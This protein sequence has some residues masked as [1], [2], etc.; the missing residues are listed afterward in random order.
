MPEDTGAINTSLDL[1][2][3]RQGH[4]IS[5]LTSSNEDGVT[6]NGLSGFNTDVEVNTT[7]VPNYRGIALKGPV[8]VQGWGRD[9]NGDPVPLYVDDEGSPIL[10]IG[11]NKQ[12]S[13][14][15]LYNSKKHKTGPLDIS[16]DESRGV[17]TGG[18]G[19][20]RIRFT[21]LSAAFTVGFGA[22]GCDHVVVQV[23]HISCGGTGVSV[24]DEVNVYDP[25][26]CHFNLPIELLVGLNGT[27]TLM[28]SENYQTDV[29]YVVDCVEELRNGGCMWM[30]DTLCCSEEEI[31]NG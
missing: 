17:W 2:P 25:E 31:I 12:F 11:G 10:D 20:P 30:I 29:S 5:L 19:A 7:G 28:K 13:P 24:G 18:G 16:W 26:Y 8:V 6:Q 27:A 23:N 9:I 3:L 15:Y 21:I 1:Y 4:D 22:L 14:D